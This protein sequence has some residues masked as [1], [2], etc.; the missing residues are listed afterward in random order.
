MPR[1]RKLSDLILEAKAKAEG[2]RVKRD[3]K[4]W[5]VWAFVGWQRGGWGQLADYKTREEAW[6]SILDR[7][8]LL[9]P[10]E[11]KPAQ[12]PAMIRVDAYFD[13]GGY[14]DYGP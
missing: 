14:E 4:A 9:E 8:G 13:P 7:L 5:R 1:G 6:V 12:V 10:E 2:Y 11:P 3:G